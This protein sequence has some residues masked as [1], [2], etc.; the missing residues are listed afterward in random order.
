ME[1]KRSA[2][3]RNNYFESQKQEAKRVKIYNDSLNDLWNSLK[4]RTSQKILESGKITYEE[5]RQI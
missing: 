5:L 4:F 2:R 1:G 3:N